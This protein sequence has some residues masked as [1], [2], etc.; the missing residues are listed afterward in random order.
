MGQLCLRL[1]PSVI[2]GD[3]GASKV[4]S[5]S[6]SGLPPRENKALH[7]FRRATLDGIPNLASMVFLGSCNPVAGWP[8][9]ENM[10]LHLFQRAA[11]DG[12]SKV[13]TL[14]SLTQDVRIHHRMSRLT[15]TKNAPTERRVVELAKEKHAIM[16]AAR[17]E[18]VLQQRKRLSIMTNETNFDMNVRPHQQRIWQ[19]I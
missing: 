3:A 9:Q 8:P 13:V 16:N 5:E 14:Y 15:A 17:N 7:L 12:S 19:G 4:P 2:G 1:V 10:A 18:S 11:L 6:V